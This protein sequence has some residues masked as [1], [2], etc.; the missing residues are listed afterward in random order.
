M[1]GDR[2]SSGVQTGENAAVNNWKQAHRFF[3]YFVAQKH[4]VK[5]L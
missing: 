5:H 4:S 1:D 3:Y 2:L